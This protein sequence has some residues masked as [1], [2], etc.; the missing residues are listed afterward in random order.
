MLAV[1]LG[2]KWVVTVEASKDLVDVARRTIA[3]NCLQHRIRV[4]HK[5]STEVCKCSIVIEYHSTRLPPRGRFS[6]L[7][8]KNGKVKQNGF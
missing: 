4:L 8:I 5:V 7:P 6:H 3:A 1:Q 2:A